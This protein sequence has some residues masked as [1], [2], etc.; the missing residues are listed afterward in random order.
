MKKRGIRITSVFVAVTLFATSG[1]NLVKGGISS[2]KADIEFN[3]T[4]ENGFFD[5]MIE[6]NRSDMFARTTTVEDY[7]KYFV[8]L[9]TTSLYYP[10]G[11]TYTDQMNEYIDN[12]VKILLFDCPPITDPEFVQKYGYVSLGSFFVDDQKYQ[13]FRDRMYELFMDRLSE[14]YK[15]D[16]YGLHYSPADVK[17]YFLKSSGRIQSPAI[18]SVDNENIRYKDLFNRDLR[19]GGDYDSWKPFDYIAIGDADDAYSDNFRCAIVHN[20][21]N[22]LYLKFHQSHMTVNSR[23]AFDW[24][25]DELVKFYNYFVINNGV[26]NKAH[27]SQSMLSYEFYLDE[28]DENYQFRFSDL[29]PKA[30]EHIL[31]MFTF[32]TYYLWNDSDKLNDYCALI[33]IDSSTVKKPTINSVQPDGLLEEDDEIVDEPSDRLQYLEENMG[34]TANNYD[35]IDY[36]LYLFDNQIMYGYMILG[37]QPTFK[38]MHMIE[39][40]DLY[41]DALSTLFE[42]SS[43]HYIDKYLG[44]YYEGL[45][46][47]GID[48]ISEYNY[49]VV[50]V[51]YVIKHNLLGELDYDSAAE[52]MEIY[53]WIGKF[54]VPGCDVTKDELDSMI[55]EYLLN[56]SKAK[57]LSTDP[58]DR[59]QY[60]I[61]NI[62]NGPIHYDDIDYSKYIFSEDFFYNYLTT[63]Y[64]HKDD[65]ATSS[66]DY[67]FEFNP[68][69]E[70]LF[71]Y[72]FLT[73]EINDDA[74][75]QYR[76]YILYDIFGVHGSDFYN[77]YF[78]NYFEGYNDFNPENIVSCYN[79][80]LIDMG[81]LRDD[82]TFRSFD[83]DVI[84]GMY[85]S[86]RCI[87]DF[88]REGCSVTPEELNRMIDENIAYFESI[89][90]APSENSEVLEEIME[91]TI[92]AEELDITVDPS[93]VIVSALT[94]RNGLVVEFGD[95]RKVFTYD[96]NY[97]HVFGT[98]YSTADDVNDTYRFSAFDD[99][100]SWDYRYQVNFY[101]EDGF[102]DDVEACAAMHNDINVELDEMVYC[103]NEFPNDACDEYNGFVERI[104]RYLNCEQAA[105]G[106][107]QDS[108]RTTRNQW[109]FYDLSRE[110]REHI[111]SMVEVLKDY[112]VEGSPYTPEYIDEMIS[113]Y[114]SIYGDTNYSR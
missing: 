71:D 18:F 87:G 91:E 90:L 105:F 4:I 76:N 114:R 112:Y 58:E 92:P 24:S 43:Y 107:Y 83:M 63:Y 110:G 62:W 39:G 65:S 28:F 72:S 13:Q 70:H 47:S 97:T 96:G 45:K 109:Y 104:F 42:L 102:S 79:N 80:A 111:Y 77:H 16:N 67:N 94:N 33:G 86:F 60:L 41:N 40:K 93:T 6:K 9:I 20:V 48:I 5:T 57:G 101:V 23:S 56:L 51:Q 44:I 68:N 95:G 22:D 55:D 108:E 11:P 38:D 10:Q 7:Y 82:E 27:A 31:E 106:R 89:K 8:S 52:I 66:F 19:D 75:I 32:A 61:D 12:L 74:V 35:S 98:V 15:K 78:H 37:I 53:R 84:R 46:S 17:S 99:F 85:E 21:I 36:S 103:I 34:R 50:D 2:A 25:Y 100:D 26:I 14:K 29:S 64:Y 113:E 3:P 49:A 81:Y 1:F 88:Y 73:S 59:L 69:Y 30:Q 54:Y